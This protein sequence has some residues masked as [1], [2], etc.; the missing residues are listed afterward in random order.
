MLLKDEIDLE[1]AKILVEN[2]TKVVSEGANMPT[3]IRSY[4]SI[5]KKRVIIWAS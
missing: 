3:Y 5:S 1:S 2:G 4:R